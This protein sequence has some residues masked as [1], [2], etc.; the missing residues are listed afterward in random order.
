MYNRI[1]RQWVALKMTE[2]TVLKYIFKNTFLLTTNKHNWPPH[3]QHGA[4]MKYIKWYHTLKN[5]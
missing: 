2:Q 4:T 3:R 5:Q 1:W